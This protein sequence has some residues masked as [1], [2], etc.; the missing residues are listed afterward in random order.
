[1]LREILG[2]IPLNSTEVSNYI[3][4]FLSENQFET[5]GG[6]RI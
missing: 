4:E 3:K 5:D 6:Y 1:M 2:D